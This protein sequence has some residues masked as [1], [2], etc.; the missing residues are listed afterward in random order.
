LS[1]Q[2]FVVLEAKRRPMPQPRPEPQTNSP[3]LL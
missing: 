3:S 2:E 1:G